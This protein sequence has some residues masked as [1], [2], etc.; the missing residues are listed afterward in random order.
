M[1]AALPPVND[2]CYKTLIRQGAAARRSYARHPPAG[3]SCPRSGVTGHNHEMDG[4]TYLLL[5][6]AA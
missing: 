3:R 1:F 6:D 4:D 2:L 5:D